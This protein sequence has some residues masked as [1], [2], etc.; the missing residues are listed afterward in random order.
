MHAINRRSQS[1]INLVDIAKTYYTVN[2]FIIHFTVNN[3][4]FKVLVGIYIENTSCSSFA[5]HFSVA[6][7]QLIYRRSVIKR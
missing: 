3:A 1:Q 4:K 6:K 7:T 5:S 2:S